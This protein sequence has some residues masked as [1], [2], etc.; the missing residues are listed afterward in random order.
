MD[1]KKISFCVKNRQIFVKVITIL[2]MYVYG[3]LLKD[4]LKLRLNAVKGALNVIKR[5]HLMTRWVGLIHIQT[6]NKT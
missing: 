5:D 1:V 6:L 3:T 2:S 4:P